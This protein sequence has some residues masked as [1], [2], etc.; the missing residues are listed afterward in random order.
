M[1]LPFGNRNYQINTSDLQNKASKLLYRTAD[2]K[3]MMRSITDQLIKD[4]GLNTSGVENADVEEDSHDDFLYLRKKSSSI[5]MSMIVKWYTKVLFALW[6]K[7][8]HF[9]VNEVTFFV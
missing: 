1:L 8:L 7:V 9:S 2:I 5:T 3:S 6:H 4:V